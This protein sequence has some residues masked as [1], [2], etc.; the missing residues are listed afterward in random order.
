VQRRKSESRS[1]DLIEG[2]RSLRRKA[3]DNLVK[4]RSRAELMA[5]VWAFSL[6]RTIALLSTY[7][8]QAFKSVSY[9]AILPGPKLIVLGAVHGS[10]KCGTVAIN[11]VISEIDSGHIEIKK[12]TVTFVPVTN[13]KAYAQN[14][15]NGDRNLNRRL[16]P[17][18][19]PAEFEDHIANW[20]CPLLA[21]HDALLDLHSFQA[22]GRPF[23]TVGPEN[24]SGDLQPFQHAEKELAMVKRLGVDRV[25]DGWLNTYAV[26]VDR[27][28]ASRPSELAITE[29]D[30]QYG[31]GT[32]EYMRSVGGYAITLECG[33]HDDPNAPSV[34]YQAI[35]NTLSHLGLVEDL[36]PQPRS[37]EGLT[38]FEVIDKLHDEDAFV[39]PWQ[40]FDAIQKGA[41]IGKRKN[42]ETMIAAEDGWIVFPNA[43]APAGNEWFYLARA[44]AR[45]A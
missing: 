17:E 2:R 3:C 33:Q 38:L 9:S 26:G 41:L 8:M 24:N 19:Q 14:T 25:V 29:L 21:K 40:S 18:A 43:A 44:N 16:R 12:G 1:I 35:R 27:R 34:G 10:E 7:L 5:L 36:P 13:P 30:P 42:G 4:H 28:R 15:R 23:A 20:L 32:T 6:S 31:V 39:K 22:Q 37:M 45:F 11:R